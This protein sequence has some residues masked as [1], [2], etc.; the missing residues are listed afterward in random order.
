MPGGY[1]VPAH[2]HPTDE[3]L[4]VLQGALQV[5]MGD[6]FDQAA[7]KTLG[8]GDFAMMPAKAHHFAAAKAETIF[9][10]NAIGP[11]GITYVNP[12]DDPRNKKTSQ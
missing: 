6:K 11:F 7:L 5:G 12:D 8:P 2:W 9:Q 3:T 10:I 1:K 4:T